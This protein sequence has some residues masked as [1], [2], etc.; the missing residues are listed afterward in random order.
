M[1]LNNGI[2]A[3]AQLLDVFFLLEG[4]IQRCIWAFLLVPF[5]KITMKHDSI[6]V[7]PRL[8]VGDSR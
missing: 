1:T 7:M 2:P 3:G 4:N 5:P 8:T 6:P